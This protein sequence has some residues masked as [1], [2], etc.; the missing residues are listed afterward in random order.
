MGVTMVINVVANAILIPK[1]GIM[2]AADAALIS[3]WFMFLAGLFF[4][5]KV[6]PGY[7]MTHLLRVVLPILVSGAVMGA[8]TYLLRPAVGFIPVVVIAGVLYLLMLW[9][10]GAIQPKHLEHM[11]SLMRRAS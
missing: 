9:I 3:F 2:G 1:M 5:H 8:T 10:T 11:R 6:I 7:R 4:V